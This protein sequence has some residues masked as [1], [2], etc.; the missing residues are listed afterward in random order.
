MNISEE[1]YEIR[2]GLR[3]AEQSLRHLSLRLD[4]VEADYKHASARTEPAKSAAVVPPPLPQRSA[5]SISAAAASAPPGI[6]A[7]GL[8]DGAAF[9]EAP[10]APRTVPAEEKPRAPRSAGPSPR[11]KAPRRFGPPEGMSWEM[12]LGT[13]WLPRIGVPVIAMAVVYGFTW[14]SHQFQDAAWMPYVRVG[15]GAAIASALVAVGWKL[16]K[17]YAAY[18][19]LLMG[20]GL[21]VFYFVVFATWYIPQTRIAPS[22]EFTLVCLALLVAGWGAIAQWRQSVVVALFMTLLGHFTVA[23]S[24]LTLESPSRAAIGGLLLLGAGSVWFLYRNGWYI[25]ALTAMAGSYLNQFF[26]LA[27]APAGGSVPEFTAG[28]L[29][30]AAYLVLFAVADRITPVRFAAGR[31]RLRNVYCGMNTGGFVLL[32]IALFSGFDFARPYDYVLYFVTAGF[33][34]ALGVSYTRRVDAAFASVADSPAPVEDPLSSIYFTKASALTAVGFAA[35]M[36]GAT[37]TLSLALQSLVL[38]LAARKSQRPVGRILALGA[39]A[40]TFAHGLYTLADGGAPHFG[41]PGA[42]GYGLVLF[43]TIAVLGVVS[44]LYRITPWH[45]YFPMQ[46]PCSWHNSAAIWSGGPPPTSQRRAR[47]GWWLRTCWY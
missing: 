27:K 3:D 9:A 23:L 19:R 40:L 47:A 44:E 13:Y 25:V 21:G 20:G 7:A 28:M 10:A 38:L 18:G 31:A 26:W 24:T 35:W 4:R 2:T 33:A 39:A 14:V 30:L 12:A 8:P 37:V 11:P 42:L 6:P 15:L 46:G 41:E 1:I 45:R 36:D 17:K 16:E 32:G 22:Q 43:G 29:V 34:L 5:P